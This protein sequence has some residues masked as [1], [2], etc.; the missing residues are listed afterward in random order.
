MTRFLIAL[1]VV[2]VVAAMVACGGGSDN[3]ATPVPTEESSPT[4]QDQIFEKGVCPAGST[5]APG[6]GAGVAAEGRLVLGFA[7][8][9]TRDQAIAFLEAQGYDYRV[10]ALIFESQTVAVICVTP[11]QEDAVTRALPLGGILSFVSRDR[12][13]TGF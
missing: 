12:G 7:P 8:D 4:P 6:G 2:L 1:A 3:S 9:T 5:P 10:S 13:G 11:G